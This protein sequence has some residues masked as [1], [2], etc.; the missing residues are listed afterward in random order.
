[1]PP[2]LVTWNLDKWN[3]WNYSECV[4]ETQNGN[5]VKEPWSVRKTDIPIGTK[6]VLVIQNSSKGFAGV[7][8][9]GLTTDVVKSVDIQGT[10]KNS[11]P[12]DW[13]VLLPFEALI[14]Y[15]ELNTLAPTTHFQNQSSG[16][17]TIKDK[18]EEIAVMNE[19]QKRHL[20]NRTSQQT[21]DDKTLSRLKTSDI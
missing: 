21:L 9:Y 8:G 12:I 11:V 1:M 17:V 15:E 19:I 7:L 13:H 4:K 10:S 14:T 18:N 6:V 2:V 5:S 3:G 20:K 16:W